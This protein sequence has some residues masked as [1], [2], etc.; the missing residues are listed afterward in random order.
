[1][2]PRQYARYRTE[3]GDVWDTRHYDDDKPVFR[4]ERGREWRRVAVTGREYATLAA[5]S[6]ELDQQEAARC[7]V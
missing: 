4:D 5:A 2:T 1:M 3:A 6:A 7:T